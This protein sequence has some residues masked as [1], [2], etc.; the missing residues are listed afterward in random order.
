MG[1][2]CPQPLRTPY[3]MPKPSP[4]EPSPLDPF[5][6][7]R[8][9]LTKQIYPALSDEDFSW[10]NRTRG[11]LVIMGEDQEDLESPNAKVHRLKNEEAVQ[12][13]IKGRQLVNTTV[14][15][16]Y[17][18]YAVPEHDFLFDG[19]HDVDRTAGCVRVVHPI[20]VSIK[21][22]QGVVLQCIVDTGAPISIFYDS[23]YQDDP[24]NSTGTQ[25]IANEIYTSQHGI[26]RVTINESTVPKKFALALVNRKVK[27]YDGIIGYDLLSFCHMTVYRGKSL[28]VVST[29][30]N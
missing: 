8:I 16:W 22:R 29:E 17:N 7:S 9:R 27:G 10:M 18:I 1:N 6:E 21:G 19:C 12:K 5:G 23:L 25:T 14:I 20:F 3:A 26:C 28:L 15:R 2:T 4:L 11:S 13:L 30:A 24:N